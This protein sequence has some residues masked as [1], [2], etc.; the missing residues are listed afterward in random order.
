[1]AKRPTHEE[2]HKQNADCQ[3]V[4]EELLKLSHAVK[5]S[6]SA[7]IITDA[8]GIIEYV[9][10][11]FVDITG[12]TT[13]EIV[14]TNAADL[15]DQ[16]PEEEAEMWD[17]IRSGSVW[18][19]EFRNKRKSGEGYWERASISA[20]RNQDGLITHYVKVAEDITELKEAQNALRESQRQLFEQEKRLEILKF[21]NDMALKFMHELR[22]PLVSI[23][24]F[25]ERISRGKYGK[26]EVMEYTGI[27][28]QQAKKLDKA[29]N[30]L[31]IQ[32]KA[33]AVKA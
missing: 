15:G 16:T 4:E 8:Q 28:Y 19:G 26:D 22:N 1:M 10:P 9:N 13:E 20:I 33:A 23:G 27:I 24:G 11:K 30:E 32:L 14:G 17:S 31:L 6:S 5:Q 18:R 3:S 21:A 12:F 29:L 7:I 2:P 25:S